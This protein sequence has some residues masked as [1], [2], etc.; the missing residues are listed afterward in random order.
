M[1]DSI[2]P[3]RSMDNNVFAYQLGFDIFL[4]GNLDTIF[5]F[6]F[7]NCLQCALDCWS[8]FQFVSNWE[9][10]TISSEIFIIECQQNN[11][12]N[13]QIYNIF[14]QRWKWKCNN[15]CKMHCRYSLF[16][17]LQVQYAQKTNFQLLILIGFEHSTWNENILKFDLFYSI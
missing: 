1:V 13:T 7:W 16:L 8:Q 6:I 3:L 14:C 15:I 4:N 2:F 10:W 11:T 12:F 17:H 9:L 5:L